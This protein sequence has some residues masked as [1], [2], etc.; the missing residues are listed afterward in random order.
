MCTGSALAL[1][2]FYLLKHLVK[3]AHLKEE[4][5]ISVGRFDLPVLLHGWREALRGAH[6]LE[7]RRVVP[8]VAQLAPLCISLLLDE[9][10]AELARIAGGGGGG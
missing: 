3:L 4:E 7:G 1:V 8:S 2:V 5:H 10:M 6:N 9:R